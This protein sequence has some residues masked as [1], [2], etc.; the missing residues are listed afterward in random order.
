VYDCAGMAE[1]AK[2]KIDGH[3]GMQLKKSEMK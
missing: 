1:T 2:R 3:E